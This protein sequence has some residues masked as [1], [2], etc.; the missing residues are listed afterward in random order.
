MV[1]RKSSSQP[2]NA[3]A[4]LLVETDVLVRFA[5]A[6]Y[7]RACTITVI[8]AAGADDAKA[9]LVAGPE[10]AILLSGAA[11]AEGSGF[12]LAQWVRR[13]RPRMEVILTASSASKAQA[14]SDIAARDPAC[15][16]PGDAAQLTAKLNALLAERKRRLR[17]QPK[18]APAK[19]KRS[20]A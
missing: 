16:P 3:L 13:H 19:R 15:R 9:I 6:D 12:A 10:C 8:E 14:A 1:A 7:L 11:L 2:K 5:I 20:R 17:Q 4:V 18:T